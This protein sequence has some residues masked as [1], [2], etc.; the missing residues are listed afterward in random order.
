MGPHFSDGAS[1]GLQIGPPA[2]SRPAIDLTCKQHADQPIRRLRRSTTPGAKK[3]RV[4]ADV[5]R[6]KRS[7]CEEQRDWGTHLEGQPMLVIPTAFFLDAENGFDAPASA[8]DISPLLDLLS[9]L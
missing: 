2:E 3:L 5:L 6:P 4:I 8:A 7:H 1:H 9:A